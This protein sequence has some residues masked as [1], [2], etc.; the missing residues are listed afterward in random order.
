MINIIFSLNTVKTS[1]QSLQTG[2][3]GVQT[4][5]CLFHAFNNCRNETVMIVLS[6]YMMFKSSILPVHS[7]IVL[8]NRDSF[9]VL[10]SIVTK[11]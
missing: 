1:F 3:I 4:N 5:G 7:V 11:H 8:S 9:F 10:F 6:F 2:I